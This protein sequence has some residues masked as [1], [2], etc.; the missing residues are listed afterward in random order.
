MNK[1]EWFVADS[2][3]KGMRNKEPDPVISVMANAPG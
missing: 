3:A 2:S 1:Q